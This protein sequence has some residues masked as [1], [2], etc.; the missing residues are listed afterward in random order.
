MA[1]DI[2]QGPPS[3]LERI[4]TASNFLRGT[5]REW[6]L[7]PLTGS[8]SEDDTQLTKFHGT[9]Q[10][11]DRDI[12]LRRQRKKLE[13]AYTFMIRVGLPGGTCSADQWAAMDKLSSDYA[14]NTLKLTTRQA[15]QLHGVLKSDLW[16]TMHG[17]NK[18]L[19]T[20]LAACGDVC[21]NTMGTPNP[22]ASPI[23]QQVDELV[24]SI[25][26]FV[27]PNTRAYYELWVEGEKLL[28][29]KQIEQEVKQEQADEQDAEPL[30]G[31]TYLPRKFKIG[32]AI[33]PHNDVDVF[34]QDL[35]FTAIEED[36][37]LA[38][39]NV[40]CGGGMGMTHGM[41]ETYPRLGSIIGFCTPDQVQDVTEHI[42]GIQRDYGDRSNRKH[43]RFKYTIDDRGVDWLKGELASR[44]GYALQE[45]RDYQFDSM[46]DQYGWAQG[47]DGKWYLTIFVEHGRVRDTDD[48][49][50]KA[51]L[52]EI[53][54][55]DICDFR[56][57]GNQGLILGQIAKKDKAKI[58]KLLKKHHVDVLMQTSQARLNSI[59]CAALP[60]CAL[61]MAESERYLPTLMDKI[62]ELLKKHD[63]FDDPI[64]IRMTGCP[65]GCGR[66][67][68][69]EIGFV[70]KSMGHYNMYLGAAFNGER[71]NK[72]YKESITE[73]EILAELDDLFAKYVADRQDG[74][75]FGDFVIRAGII[76][77]TTEGKNFHA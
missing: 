50:M 71:L 43:A 11:D 4:K 15:F 74:E 51:C 61:A 57:T 46:S 14:N 26:A 25:A 39:F 24:N 72:I 19:M 48:H 22:N 30:Y 17:I 67:Y 12:R 47:I 52:R 55:L 54:E 21:R 36:G 31:N 59:A 42:V 69:A 60:Y 58:D 8:I 10:Q 33:P 64:V 63:L 35:G 20:T 32:F 70:G 76:K 13:P 62:E 38:G 18:A 34:T 6:L 77:P 3:D 1:Q 53:A 37:Q 65:N 7:N 27:R 68:N 40:S 23:H 75:H 5:I 16:D 45:P 66:P 44:L 41:T 28:D 73:E 56:L 49:T 29:T 9:Y 2:Q